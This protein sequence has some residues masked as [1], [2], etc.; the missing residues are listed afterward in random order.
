MAIG[1]WGFRFKSLIDRK[2]VNKWPTFGIGLLF[3]VLA[4][5]CFLELKE[6]MLD[7]PYYRNKQ[8][9]TV[10]GEVMYDADE[11]G[12]E[13]REIHFL[14]DDGSEISICYLRAN[15]KRG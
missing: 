10:Q 6:Y 2:P 12:V 4:T 8:H 11:K 14:T 7:W 5:M 3:I 9:I 13:P 15:K 1:G